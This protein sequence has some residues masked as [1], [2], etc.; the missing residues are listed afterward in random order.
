V[1]SRRDTATPR[2][3]EHPLPEAV[4][5]V[6]RWEVTGPAD[7]SVI[8]ADIRRRVD[9]ESGVPD[10]ASE[11]AERLLL[12]VEEL[13]SNGLRHGGEPVS[14]AITVTDTGWLLDVS[15]AG[16]GDGPQVAVGRDPA[17]GGLGLYLTAA[18][19]TG[20]GWMVAGTRRHVWACVPFEPDQL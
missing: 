5:A 19:A 10:A 14:V 18:L 7:L 17:L 12:A 20:F 8:R 3:A 1:A 6:W 4:G 9:A 16:G 13:A 11:G 15:D 2:W